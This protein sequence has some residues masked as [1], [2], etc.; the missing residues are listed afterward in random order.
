ML[1]IAEEGK[2]EDREVEWNWRK[3]KKHVEEKRKRIED[4]VRVKYILF[5][6]L[7]PMIY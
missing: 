5:I 4:K 6:T 1:K 2:A 3:E 7:P